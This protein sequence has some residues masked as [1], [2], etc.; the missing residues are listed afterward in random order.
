MVPFSATRVHPFRSIESRLAADE[1]TG[2]L[3]RNSA[4]G[5]LALLGR[6]NRD[7]GKTIIMVTH[8][9]LAAA[10]A[11]AIMQLDKGEL[12]NEASDLSERVD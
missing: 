7:L 8:D 5:V 9:H 11:H 10:S 12:V 6:L 3:D 4:R 1:P 2:D